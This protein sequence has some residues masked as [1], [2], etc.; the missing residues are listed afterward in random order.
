MGPKIKKL[1]KT[2]I[3]LLFAFLAIPYARANTV[4]LAA[5]SGSYGTTNT[6]DTISLP[7]YNQAAGHCIVLLMSS[8]GFIPCCTTAGSVN[9]TAGN[10]Y[11]PPPGVIYAGVGS[12]NENYEEAWEI[13][14]VL[15]NSANVVT[16]NFGASGVPP[17]SFTE[18]AQVFYYDISPPCYGTDYA[19]VTTAGSTNPSLTLAL[20]T[21]HPLEA[22]FTFAT[23]SILANPNLTAIT[24]PSG[25]TASSIEPSSPTGI[26]I[27]A[28]ELVNTIQSSVNITWSSATTAVN[29]MM[30]LSVNLTPPGGNRSQYY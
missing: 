23:D 15:G 13:S 20:T 6:S 2:L 4:T 26:S 9:D 25:F 21:H 27:A 5:Q 30:L 29:G 18:Y 28:Y 17:G 16:I 12:P 10:N 14:N 11:G 3:F 1:Y 22:I 24:A 8:Y 7:S 19:N